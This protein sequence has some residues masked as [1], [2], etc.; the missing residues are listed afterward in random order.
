[1]GSRRARGA[2]ERRTPAQDVGADYDHAL[3]LLER[4]VFSELCVFERRERRLEPIGASARP[5]TG[6]G[7]DSHRLIEGRPL[8]LGGV[9]ITRSS[10][11]TAIPTPTCLPTR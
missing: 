4:A 1:M 6:I 11:W 2:V 3:E 8:I 7:Y 10:A 5:L 9:E